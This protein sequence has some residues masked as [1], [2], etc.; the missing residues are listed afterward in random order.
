MASLGR[1][2]ALAFKANRELGTG[3]RDKSGLD[4]SQARLRDGRPKDGG[5]GLA[6]V[7]SL[8]IPALCHG[9][10]STQAP[11]PSPSLWVADGTP[12]DTLGAV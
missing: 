5:V 6:V 9:V 11:G 4:E 3:G 7:A 2:R 8:S 10:D 12:A 1:S